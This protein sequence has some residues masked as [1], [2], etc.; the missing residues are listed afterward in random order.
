[1]QLETPLR[2]QHEKSG[3][4]M[5]TF[6]GYLLPAHF[7]D[8]LTEYQ[9]ARESVAVL[10]TNYRAVAFLEGADRV[11][12]LNAVTTNNIQALAPGQGAPGLLLN[13]QGH[14]LAELDCYAFPDRLLVLSHGAVRE[15]TVATLDKYI[16]MDDA[17]LDDAT[18]R[19][20]SVAL[21]GPKAATIAKELGGIDVGGMAEFSIL[22][23]KLGSIPCHVV[24]RS[25]FGSTGVEFIVARAALAEVWRMLIEA[26]RARGGG[27][28]GYAALNTLRLEA[29]IP[30]FSYDFDDT[31]IPQEAA[32]ENSHISFTKGC[33]TGQE[34]VERVRSRGHVNRRR[35]GLRF[36]GQAPPEK[37]TKLLADGKDAGHVTSA[38][39]SLALGHVIGMG[40]LRR[41]HNSVGSEVAWA[42]GAAT[43][44]ELPVALHARN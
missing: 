8:F 21:E 41:E 40:Y 2:E 44:I 4:V 43:V 13:P 14:I 37:G 5:G 20:A 31:V 25:N 29:G 28:V 10:D 34:I 16:I 30:W 3:G 9:R 33:Y 19:F 7:T 6:F 38:A 36:S 17:T 24:R 39:F 11:R 15:R 35:V 1:M 42:E 26:A 22:E 32:L 18:E 27:P 23:A 12:Y